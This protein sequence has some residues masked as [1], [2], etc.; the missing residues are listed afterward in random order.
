ML[1]TKAGVEQTLAIWKEFERARK[2]KRE[3]EGEFEQRAGV[4]TRRP[5]GIEKSKKLSMNQSI[6]TSQKNKIKVLESKNIT[7]QAI[8]CSGL[9]QYHLETAPSWLCAC[10][11]HHLLHRYASNPHLKTMSSSQPLPGST[12][13]S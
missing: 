1:Y 6:N 11:R 10:F 13:F 8:R 5:A 4:G 7:N 9:D 12:L 3:E 2:A